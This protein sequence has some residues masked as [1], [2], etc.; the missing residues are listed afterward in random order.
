VRGRVVT[1]KVK[2]KR[3]ISGGK[4]TAAVLTAGLSLFATGLS[5]KDITT[6]AKCLNC[7]AEWYF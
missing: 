6:K 5:R 3:G 4:A 2:V 7:N 1:E